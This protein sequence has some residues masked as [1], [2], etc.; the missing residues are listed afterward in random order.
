MFNEY[1]NELFTMTRELHQAYIDLHVKKIKKIQQIPFEYRRLCYN[2]H[3][4]HLESRQP[5]TFAKV[6]NFVNKMD[7]PLQL[8]TINYK[9]R[10][11]ETQEAPVPVEV[12]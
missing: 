3:G 9:F 5:T 4:E 10:L 7:I 8:F 11:L 6:K 1:Q 2:I 12:N